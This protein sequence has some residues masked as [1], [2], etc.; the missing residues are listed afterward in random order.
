VKARLEG[1]EHEGTEENRQK[2]AEK[3]VLLVVVIVVIRRPIAA[4]DAQA[5]MSMILGKDEPK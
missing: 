5:E 2:V 1:T 3:A 4:L